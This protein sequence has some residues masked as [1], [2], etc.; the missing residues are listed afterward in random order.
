MWRS[1]R[2]AHAGEPRHGQSR[3]T[4]TLDYGR[5]HCRRVRLATDAGEDVLLDLS[6]AVVLRDGDA[7]VV[8]EGGHVTVRAAAEACVELTAATPELL[9]KLAWHIGNRH[10]PAEIRGD[11]IVIPDDHVI[12]E[13]ASGLGASAKRVRMPFN[14]E[15]GAYSDHGHSHD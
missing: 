15:R 13:M 11:R 10:F 1:H 2:I 14:P 4:V 9:A 8:E 6:R 5:R 7:L 12:V 3:G